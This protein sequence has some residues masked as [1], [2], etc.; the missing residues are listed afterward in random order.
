MSYHNPTTQNRSIRQA[1]IKCPAIVLCALFLQALPLLAAA[2]EAETVPGKIQASERPEETP[3]QKE[4][5]VD[6]DFWKVIQPKI[7][8]FWQDLDASSQAAESTAWPLIT[9]LKRFVTLFPDSPFTPQAYYVLGEAFAAVS[10]FPEAL[11]HWKI[12][13]KHYPQSPWAGEALTALVLHL[14]RQGDTKGIRELYLEIVRQFP[15][16]SAAKAAWISMALNALRAGKVEEVAKQVELLESKGKNIY[17]DVP[18]FLDLKARLAVAKGR[19]ENARNYWLHY[20]NLI[21]SPAQRAAILFRIA[22]SYRRSGKPI[23]AQ[24]Y[25]LILKRDYPNQPESLFARFR[26]AQMES[27]GRMR[28]ARYIS[29]LQ[30]ATLNA[31]AS[32]LYAKII[33]LYPRHPITQEVE[34]EF[35]LLKLNQARFTEALEMA[36]GFLE[37]T[38][39][40]PLAPRVKKAGF[41][42][43]HAL[44]S[45]KRNLEILKRT[46]A[47]GRD[48]LDRHPKSPFRTAL[49]D[50]TQELWLDYVKTLLKQKDYI[51]ALEQAWGLKDFAEDD[52][53]KSA[54]ELAEKALIAHDEDLLS[55]GRYIDLLNYHYEHKGAI[56]SMGV[57][58]HYFFMARAWN[59]LLCPRA[60]MRH[61]YKAWEIGPSSGNK[62]KFL[63]EWAETAIKIKDIETAHA[64]LALLDGSNT[65]QILELQAH[66]AALQGDWPNARILSEKILQ[67]TIGEEPPLSLQKLL[68]TSYVKLAEWNRLEKMWPK[69]ARQLDVEDKIDLLRLWGD[70]ALELMEYH[71]ALYAYNRLVALV[72]EAPEAEWRIALAHMRAGN[73]AMAMEDLKVIAQGKEEPWRSAAKGLLENESFWNGPAGEF[74]YSTPNL[75]M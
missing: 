44:K 54:Q 60:A 61:L 70:T 18:Q 63:V 14:E 66:L 17:I 26:L 30:Q 57:A 62:E 64:V 43:V 23:Q 6:K 51:A 65:P 48:F 4:T 11:A 73:T 3:G 39:H 45:E 28:L 8:T 1:T 52:F 31:K 5:L 35:I 19:E 47:F 34:M 2:P 71:P 37:R 36:Q 12:V 40:S 9:A 15:D 13:A 55:Q 72:P 22:E 53:S 42:A 67:G 10:Y 20:L 50:V 38:P 7:Q 41:K 29:G 24:K 68:F 16:S 27:T 46:V 32:D 25:Y 49:F 59:A 33:K 56:S 58:D 21:R 69:L 75:D 74:R